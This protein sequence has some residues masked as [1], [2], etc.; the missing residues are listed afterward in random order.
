MPATE[1][2]K[3]KKKKIVTTATVSRQSHANISQFQRNMNGPV[4]VNRQSVQQ[5]DENDYEGFVLMLPPAGIQLNANGGRPLPDVR[6]EGMRANARF[7]DIA[8]DTSTDSGAYAVFNSSADAIGTDIKY[9]DSDEMEFVKRELSNVKSILNSPL[10]KPGGTDIYTLRLNLLSGLNDLQLACENHED[11]KRSEGKYESSERRK[12]ITSLKENISFLRKFYRNLSDRQLKSMSGGAGTFGGIME[13]YHGKIAGNAE[14]SME[15]EALLRVKRHSDAENLL[16]SLYNKKGNP[17]DASALAN[18]MTSLKSLMSKGIPQSKKAV[19]NNKADIVK[20]YTE[21][22]EKCKDYLKPRIF[23]PNK[24][25]LEAVRKIRSIMEKELR[26]FSGSTEE[27]LKHIRGNGGSWLDVVAQ[28]GQSIVSAQEIGEGNE[29]TQ[30]RTKKSK[31]LFSGQESEAGY[32]NYA[33]SKVLGQGSLYMKQKRAIKVGQDGSLEKGFIKEEPIRAERDKQGMKSYDELMEFAK[34]KEM[35]TVYS[36][37]A[38]KQLSVLRIMDFLSGRKSRDKNSLLYDIEIKLVEGEDSICINR[39]ISIDNNEAIKESGDSDASDAGLVNDDGVFELPYDTEFADRLI[40]MDANKLLIS[41]QREGARLDA[42][43]QVGLMKRLELLQGWLKNDKETGWRSGVSDQERT[44]EERKNAPKDKKAALTDIRKGFQN[45]DKLP[46]YMQGDFVHERKLVYVP[47]DKAT[48]E[49]DAENPW[50]TKD[51]KRVKGVKINNSVKKTLTR[52]QKLELKRKKLEIMKKFQQTDS[53][54]ALLLKKSKSELLKSVSGKGENAGEEYRK[55]LDKIK[56][57]AG[58]LATS[59]WEER[60]KWVRRNE[61]RAGESDAQRK[62][63]VRTPEKINAERKLMSEIRHDIAE[64]QKSLNEKASG[65][66]LSPAEE[67]ELK[68]LDAYSLQFNELC[69]G[70]L[71]VPAKVGGK[72]PKGVRFADEEETPL[73]KVI[74][75]T[76][77]YSEAADGFEFVSKKGVKE[78]DGARAYIPKYHSITKTSSF[79]TRD[80]SALPLFAHEP[81]MEDVVQGRLGDCYLLAGLASLVEKSP[82]TIKDMMRDNGDGSVTV[83]FYDTSGGNMETVY[84]RVKK[85]TIIEDKEHQMM[86]RF[87][88]NCL[89][90]HMIEKAFAVSGLGSKMGFGARKKLELGYLDEGEIEEDLWATREIEKNNQRTFRS[91]SGGVAGIFLQSVLGFSDNEVGLNAMDNKDTVIYQDLKKRDKKTGKADE[92]IFDRRIEHLMQDLKNAES[93]GHIVNAGGRASIFMKMGGGQDEE[94]PEYTMRGFVGMHEF[95][96]LGVRTIDGEDF[97]AVRNPW[98]VEVAEHV[99]NES[100]GGIKVRRGHDAEGGAFLVTPMEFYKYFNSYTIVPLKKGGQQ[101]P[102]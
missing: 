38:L 69:D 1:L 47:K 83:R 14:V 74:V 13:N 71:K 44:K 98:G 33:L 25:R 54:S 37:E 11:K 97:I 75:E 17:G 46:A 20:A 32:E 50:I 5:R 2:V 35:D 89:W 73:V 79:E 91:I 4:N 57:Y 81:C 82:D 53:K 93:K 68:E 92:T 84:V 63:R 26:F 62:E 16:K 8:Q 77:E 41:L 72:A 23:R 96:V 24:L 45:A 58:I 88:R 86:D 78:K 36:L 60:D 102:C 101:K 15:N 49:Q 42:A 19:E 87:A 76:R 67:A 12:K 51:G 85:E 40:Q 94:H 39:V 100:T 52:E 27:G 59:Q 43:K 99:L 48:F 6:Q 18:S 31:Q 66:G 30:M 64:R 55:I 9:S 21:I 3:G 22:L 29:L 65:T 70:R 7:A 61:K 95:S 90:V 56:S 10:N 80:D 34:A 28:G